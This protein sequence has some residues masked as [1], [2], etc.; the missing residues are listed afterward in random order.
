MKLCEHIAQ[1]YRNEI[2]HGNEP[3]FVYTP[4][5]VQKNAIAKM[6]VIMKNKLQNY[7]IEGVEEEFVIDYHFPFERYYYCTECMQGISG[8]VEENQK[9]WYKYSRFDKTSEKV[10]ATRDNV[11]IEDGFYGMDL[12][13]TK[14]FDN[15]E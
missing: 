7:C 13:P 12:V 3:L 8:P 6:Y 1:I 5:Y 9:I 4:N 10:V 2:E 11:Y 14:K 15:K